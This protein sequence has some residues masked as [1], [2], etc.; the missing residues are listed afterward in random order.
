MSSIWAQ[1]CEDSRSPHDAARRA[2]SCEAAAL[3]P[4]QFEVLQILNEVLDSAQGAERAVTNC[5]AA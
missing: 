4:R 1:Y 2:P 5:D 3:T